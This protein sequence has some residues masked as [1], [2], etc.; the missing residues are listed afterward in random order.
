MT[1]G[2]K[3]LLYATAGAAAVALILIVIINIHDSQIDKRLDTLESKI[4]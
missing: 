4:K 2:E 1:E 3:G